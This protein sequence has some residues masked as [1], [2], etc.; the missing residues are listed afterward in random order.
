MTLS[1][2]I[3]YMILGINQLFYSKIKLQRINYALI[4][5]VDSGCFQIGV[6]FI[7]TKR[8]AYILKK[9]NGRLIF[10]FFLIV[11]LTFKKILYIS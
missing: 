11:Q 4:L 1:Y 2:F 3:K 9:K 5:Q 7:K 10:Y 6:A 8:E